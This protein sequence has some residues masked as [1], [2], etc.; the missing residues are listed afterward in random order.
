M[1]KSLSRPNKI[2]YSARILH[3]VE[4]F[5]FDRCEILNLPEGK[6]LGDTLDGKETADKGVFHCC[7]NVHVVTE[8]LGSSLGATG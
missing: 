1:H 3:G 5:Q 8:R 2:N 6:R 7:G 4:S